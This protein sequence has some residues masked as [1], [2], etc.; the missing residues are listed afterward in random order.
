MIIRR[1]L[2]FRYC[3]SAFNSDGANALRGPAMTIAPASVGNAWFSV[4]PVAVFVIAG[5]HP[6]QAGPG[7]LLDALAA[8]FVV[9]FA[10][11]AFRFAFE[12]GVTLASQLRDMWVYGV[13]AALSP[14]GLLAATQIHSSPLAGLAVVPLLGLLAIFAHDDHPLADLAV[15]DRGHVLPPGG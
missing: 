3:S 9:D 6:S 12:R 8:Q 1:P 14:I 5:I 4:G 10:V 13:D 11:S 7:L 15:E 2:P